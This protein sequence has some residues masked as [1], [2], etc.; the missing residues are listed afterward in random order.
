M[1]KRLLFC[2]LLPAF[3]L[4]A[5]SQEGKRGM[6][7][8]E[9]K[10]LLPTLEGRGRVR[11]L[12]KIAFY[13]IKSSLV[14]SDSGLVYAHQ[15]WNA[16]QEYGYPPELCTATSLYADVLLQLSRP[17]EGLI[18]YRELVRLA[19]QYGYNDYAVLGIRGI[20]Q[21]LWY[22]ANFQQAIDTITL[23]LQ[24]LREKKDTSAMLDATITLCSIYGDRGDYEKA[25]DIARE[26]LTMSV[27]TR[28]SGIII[29]SLVQLGILYKDIGDYPTAMEY[30]KRAYSLH[31]PVGMWC[32][33]YL[34]NCMGDLYSSLHQYDSAYYFYGQSFSGNRGSKASRRKLAEYYLVRQ[35]YDTAL[36][37][38]KGL[39]NDLKEGGEGH[40]YMY[41]M[42]GMG[43][44]YLA[45]KDLKKAL[46]YGHEVLGLA[47]RRNAKL[48][49]RD[50]CQLLSSV[51][52]QLKL[53]GRALDYYKQYVQMKDSVITDQFKG[54]LY[55]FKQ[56]V[57]E[58]KQ[59][60]QIKLLEKEKLISQQK[61]AAN[62]LLRNLLSGGILLLSV[63][64]FILFRNIA[65]KRK[66]E[67]LQSERIQADLQ[68]RAGELEMQALRAQM[69]PHF[70]FNCLSSINRFILKNEADEA[71][72]YLIRFSRLIRLVLINS[73][74]PLIL[75]TDEVEMLRLYIEMERLRFKDVFDYSISYT[76]KI[77]PGN[78]L[79]PPLLLQPFCENAIWH[80]LMH[81][82][83]R[84]HLSID[85][86]MQHNVLRCVITDDGVGRPGVAEIT[87]YAG[88]KIKSLGLKLTTERLA[89]FNEEKSVQTFYEIADV[90]DEQG[91]ISGTKVTLKIRY[92]E[93]ITEP[94]EPIK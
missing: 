31:P 7:I 59:Q 26:A 15:A 19:G 20:G 30:Y 42:L 89:L 49:I 6:R 65:L 53:P 66:N 88:E 79:I 13:Y 34:S 29:L 22:Q 3:C 68:H 90:L 4:P 78:V 8:R 16:A 27:N 92:R 61:L 12:N 85:F 64:G 57:E 63:L 9:L 80:G 50:A 81:K 73:E 55:A 45:R 14:Y 76:N 69:N 52:S 83:G 23:S 70:I 47:R 86:E 48:N 37:Y 40:I 5:F 18:H 36:L 72:D 62:Q 77:E 28:D 21:S 10:R 35:N 84:G 44:V 11:C 46:Y 71:S 82:E 2:L 24:Y 56:S 94:T 54:R 39:Y 51:Y 87:G 41:A 43:K 58:E 1:W 17:D 91:D 75:L 25:F 38:F 74:K 60:A 32:Y 93:S 67:K 33:R